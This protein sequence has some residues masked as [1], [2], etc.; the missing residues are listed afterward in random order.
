MWHRL[1]LRGL[2]SQRPRPVADVLTPELL[3]RVGLCNRSRLVP[4]RAGSRPAPQAAVWLRLHGTEGP[5][6]PAGAVVVEFVPE[7]RDEAAVPYHHPR[8]LRLFCEAP[9]GRRRDDACVM[10]VEELAAFLQVALAYLTPAD[11]PNLVSKAAEARRCTSGRTC[12]KSNRTRA[13]S[14]D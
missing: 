14:T 10:R 13:W 11:P 9:T 4:Q 6:P 3:Q 2:R 5:P 1:L 12:C 7:Q 8:H